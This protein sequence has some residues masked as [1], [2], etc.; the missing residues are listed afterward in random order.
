MFK[1]SITLPA[2]PKLVVPDNDAA[3]AS[4]S[5]NVRDVSETTAALKRSAAK[6]DTKFVDESSIRQETFV[7]SI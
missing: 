1:L 4:V 7:T 2:P 3:F 6:N 5:V